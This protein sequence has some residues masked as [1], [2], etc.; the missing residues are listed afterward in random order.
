MHYKND[1][2]MLRKIARNWEIT[3]EKWAGSAEASLFTRLAVLGEDYR[4][5]IGDRVPIA[6][7]WE[8]QFKAGQSADA[9]H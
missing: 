2:L 9:K 7:I 4:F 1:K 8:G 3:A 6:V 5:V